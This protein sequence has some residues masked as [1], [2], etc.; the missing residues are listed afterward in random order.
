MMARL[1]QCKKC[2]YRWISRSKNRY[3]RC[4]KC[5]SFMKPEVDLPILPKLDE[6]Q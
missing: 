3:V 2:G 4:P 5:K 1:V 6:S